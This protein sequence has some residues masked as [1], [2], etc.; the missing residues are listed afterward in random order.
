MERESLGTDDRIAIEQPSGRTH[1]PSATGTMTGEALLFIFAV[2]AAAILLFMMVYFVCSPFSGLCNNLS[3][4]FFSP[5]P[6]SAPMAASADPSFSL[7][8]GPV[9]RPNDHESPV[10]RLVRTYCCRDSACVQDTLSVHS[11]EILRDL[12]PRSLCSRI[13]KWITSTPSISATSS[14]WCVSDRQRMSMQIA[15]DRVYAIADVRCAHAR[16]PASG[17]RHSPWMPRARA[18]L[19]AHTCN[20]A[21][22]LTGCPP[23]VRAARVHVRA[24][25]PEHPNNALPH[26]PAPPRVQR[27][28]VCGT[29]SP[30]SFVL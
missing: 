5:A 30:F 26:Q 13:S 17:C 27:Q 29:L 9:R 23:R 28:E 22:A 4:Q 15:R 24:V 19:N 25:P 6:F 3:S 11:L 18:H 20:H 12:V 8:I 7:S 21:H 16:T 10:D 14:T 1:I 2:I